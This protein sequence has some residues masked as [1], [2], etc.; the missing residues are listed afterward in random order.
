MF[1]GRAPRSCEAVQP[2]DEFRI[3]SFGGGIITR[4]ALASAANGA[5]VAVWNSQ[6]G[7][8][9]GRRF[10]AS[11]T[12]LGAQF[13][14][15]FASGGLNPAIAMDA[16]GNFVVVRAAQAGI[17]GQRFD[18][19]AVPALRCSRDAGRAGVPGRS[20][21]DHVAA[22]RT[23]S[24]ISRPSPATRSTGTSWSGTTRTASWANASIPRPGPSVPP[25]S[26]TL[27][28]FWPSDARLLDVYG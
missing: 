21:R 7:L 14:I 17:F 9:R 3:D 16:A 5:F 12:P 22:R 23:L 8:I 24:R 11:G 2:G 10:D 4:P 1:S 19:S 13:L 25:S 6:D 28:R 26:W 20:V 18:A 15:T 27:C